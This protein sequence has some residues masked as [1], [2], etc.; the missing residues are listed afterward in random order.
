MQITYVPKPSVFAALNNAWHVC[1]T[2]AA[3]I[4]RGNEADAWQVLSD[5]HRRLNHGL[6]YAGWPSNG[7]AAFKRHMAATCESPT[8]AAMVA[9]IR[10]QLRLTEQQWSKLG[11]V[12]T[13]QLPASIPDGRGGEQRCSQ[14]EALKVLQAQHAWVGMEGSDPSCWKGNR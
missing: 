7:F 4:S 12:E 11:C 2:A 3:A 6:Y 5:Q 13:L 9:A 1:D 14:G 10:Q 8:A